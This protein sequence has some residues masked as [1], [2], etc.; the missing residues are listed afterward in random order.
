VLLTAEPGD[1]SWL[2]LGITGSHATTLEASVSSLSFFV[3]ADKATGS[4]PVPGDSCSGRGPT[5]GL[6]EATLS[7]LSGTIPGASINGPDVPATALTSAFI[8]S[9][10]K[11]FEIRLTD[12]ANACGYAKNN[13]YKVGGLTVTLLTSNGA[14]L[15]VRQY[16]VSEVTTMPER[17]PASQ[18]LGVCSFA[19]GGSGAGSS[20][21][22]GIDITAVDANHVVGTFDVP[23]GSGGHIAG[24]FDIPTCDA[25]PNRRPNCCVQ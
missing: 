12:Y 19:P 3:V 15:E 10:V 5:Q 17:V 7:K 16:P 20:D 18:S 22:A 14:V 24:S 21:G 9:T 1:S 8:V 2:E 23:V 25:D 13:D 6:P 4:T 11:G